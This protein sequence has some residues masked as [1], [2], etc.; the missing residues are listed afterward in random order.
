MSDCKIVI[1]LLLIILVALVLLHLLRNKT[2][3][4]TQTIRQPL[5]EQKQSTTET[6][7]PGINPYYYNRYGNLTYP[8]AYPY[9]PYANYYPANQIYNPYLNNYYALNAG[10]VNYPNYTGYNPYLNNYYA[11]NA[12]R[13]NYPYTHYDPYL[14]NV[15]YFKANIGGSTETNN[16]NISIP[17]YL[18]DVG[19][20]VS[21][22]VL[23][24]ITPH[25]DKQN[26]Y[27]VSRYYDANVDNQY[28]LLGN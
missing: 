14:Y 9:Y 25:D 24:K 28:E 11:L 27:A 26:K 13:V 19:L 8:S 18:H 20:D 6:F 22:N 21:D 16:Q 10:R 5:I 4:T 15:S 12:G 17:K 1:S 3:I 23:G 7:I 2:N